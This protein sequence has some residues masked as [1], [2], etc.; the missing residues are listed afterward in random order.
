MK[1]IFIAYNMSCENY[2]LYKEYCDFINT[3]KSFHILS[4]NNITDHNYLKDLFKMS[5]CILKLKE[6]GTNN[7]FDE[8]ELEM[9]KELNIPIYDEYNID[10]YLLN[11]KL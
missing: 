11:N 1:T 10:E 3:F 4:K 2:D 7:K 8:F 9:A 5:D 6:W